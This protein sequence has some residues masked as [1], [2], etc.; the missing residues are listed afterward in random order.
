M[1]FTENQISEILEIIDFQSTNFV[2]GNLSEIVLSHKDKLL[3]TRLGIDYRTPKGELTP[4]EQLYYFGRLAAILGPLKSKEV[5]F[6]DFKKYLR[7]GQYKPLTK[8][9]KQTLEYLQTRSYDHIKNL[10]ETIKTTVAGKIREK[11]MITLEEY[12]KTIGSSIKR[13]VLE[14]DTVKS[15]VSEIGQLTQDWERNLG[16]I[17]ETELQNAFEFGKA[18]ALFEQYGENVFYFKIPFA[19]A[20]RHCINLYLTD[21]VGSQPRLFTYRQLLENGTNIGRKVN[22]WKAVL[23]TVHPFC[24]CPLDKKKKEDVWDGELGMFIP[25]I[26][27]V[28][29]SGII[30]VSVGDKVISV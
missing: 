3:L 22:D 29:S 4:Y 16:R 17:A 30:K 23:G 9:E 26:T 19:G 25:P 28:K 20:C 13:A 14:K 24:R 21:G 11:N 12:E 1:L 7:R 18:A 8:F 15:I 5:D 6:E 2:A 27:E 10:T